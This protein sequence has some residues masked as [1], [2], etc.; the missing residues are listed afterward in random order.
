MMDV[1]TN[2]EAKILIP[3]KGHQNFVFSGKKIEEGTK[4]KGTPK[5]IEGKRRGEP[6]TYRLFITDKNEIIYLKSIDPMNTTEV[7]LGA[8]SQVSATEVNFKPA[9]KFSRAKTRGLVIGALAGFAYAKYKKH[10]LKKVAM[11]IAVGSII[12]YATGYMVDRNRKVTVTE[13]K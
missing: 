13:S 4:L 9:E 3:N 11:Y 12:G 2:E 7:T 5:N 10:D 8:D 1:I 6:F